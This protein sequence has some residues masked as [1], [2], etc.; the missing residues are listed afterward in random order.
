MRH[1]LVACLAAGA[2]GAFLTTASARADITVGATL[3]LTG[4]G[5]ALGLP[6]R[7]EFQLWPAQIAGERLNVIIL[8]DSGD[9]TQATRNAQKLTSESNV[10][11]ITGSSITPAAL[12]VV[13]VAQETQ[14]LHFAFSPV[15]LPPG[16]C[17]SSATFPLPWINSASF[18]AAVWPAP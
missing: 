2:A 11:V 4:P 15:E 14:T 13:R 8:D 1:G 5:A 3:P 6:L 17:I 18:R 7:D 10:D 16:F 12:A 9:P